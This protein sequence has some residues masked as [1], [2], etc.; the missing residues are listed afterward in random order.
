MLANK[1]GGS[2]KTQRGWCERHDHHCVH[3]EINRAAAR[4]FGA[5]CLVTAEEKQALWNNPEK[6]VA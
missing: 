2:F 5:M 1:A 4:L 3:L 6:A